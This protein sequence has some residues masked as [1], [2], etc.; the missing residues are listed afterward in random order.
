MTDRTRG[1]GEGELALALLVLA[2]GLGLLAT[3]VLTL[4]PILIAAG[5]TILAA[6]RLTVRVPQSDAAA[7]VRNALG[8]W[9]VAVRAPIIGIRRGRGQRPSMEGSAT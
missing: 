6:R 7:R 5:S 2:G 1:S 9:L 3:A 4:L 8:K